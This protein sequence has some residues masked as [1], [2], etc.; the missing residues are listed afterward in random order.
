MKKLLLTG[1]LV[2]MS[3]IW[4]QSCR[5][6]QNQSLAVNPNCNIICSDYSA[7]TFQGIDAGLVTN[8]IENYKTGHYNAFVNG[9]RRVDS[10]SVWFSLDRMKQFIYE[11]EKNTCTKGC[12]SID[13][14]GVRIYFA[15]Y[16]SEPEVWNQYPQ[17]VNELPNIYRGRH[18]LLMIPTMRMGG[19][20]T[21]FDPRAWVAKC[22]PEAMESVMSRL[23]RAKVGSTTSFNRAFVF[24]PGSGDP[25]TSLNHGTLDPPTEDNFAP[26]M[27][28]RPCTGSSLMNIVDRVNCNTVNSAQLAPGASVPSGVH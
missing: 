2:L 12:N 19:I 22:T 1:N 25:T 28:T 11:I 7:K 14:L 18:T 17:L 21:D 9:N 27:I 8:M 5:N 13:S 6:S 23:Q 24:V 3:V 10:R 4:F 26:G 16:P 20:N 15:E